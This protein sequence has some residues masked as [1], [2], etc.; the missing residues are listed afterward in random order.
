MFTGV[1]KIKR[2][3][4][5]LGH[6]SVVENCCFVLNLLTLAYG[7]QRTGERTSHHG[8]LS[9]LC[10]NRHLPTAGMPSQ[11]SGHVWCDFCNICV[12]K[13]M[14]DINQREVPLDPHSCV[15]ITHL[16][17]IP[18]LKVFFTYKHTSSPEQFL[19]SEEADEIE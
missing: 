12:L 6:R 8:I 18:P 13:N 10:H 14:K 2:R 3:K 11:C 17:R 15:V 16:S 5:R 7:R 19:I 9:D 4:S 1:L